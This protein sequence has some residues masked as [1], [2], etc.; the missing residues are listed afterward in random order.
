MSLKARTNSYG[1]FVFP[2]PFT[3]T[4]TVATSSG[5]NTSVANYVFE[6]HG[7]SRHGYSKNPKRTLHGVANFRPAADYT[8]GVFDCKTTDRFYKVTSPYGET[9]TLTEKVG[10]HLSWSWTRIGG[11]LSS[12]G[13]LAGVNWYNDTAWE[14]RAQSQIECL[15]R[16]GGQKAQVYVTLAE[17]IKSFNLLAST[18]GDL[19]AAARSLK[20]GNF[21]LAAK[22]LGLK[23][24]KGLSKRILEVN[25]GWAPLV[26][27]AIGAKEILDMYL[28][29]SP[30]VVSARRTIKTSQTLTNGGFLYRPDGAKN[31]FNN[32]K[33]RT[34]CGLTAVIDDKY[35]RIA[36]QAGAFNP[37]QLGWE[38]LPWSFIIDWVLPVGDF[39]EAMQAPVGLKF[40]TGYQSTVV[41]HEFECE[42]A[43]LP[44]GAIGQP[45]KYSGKGYVFQRSALNAWPRP[46][47]LYVK[48]PFKTRNAINALALIR[49]LI[50]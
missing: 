13:T 37:V 6:A 5:T 33:L 22:W 3:Q 36:N 48:S 39:I 7:C 9:T 2:E 10:G 46:L 31:W 27:E 25:Y 38:L 15:N 8:R 40:L 16:L 21:R 32:Q 30:L 47:P 20:H 41:E 43:P 49:Q 4:T 28:N 44:V 23:D 42:G 34:T 17:A 29:G 1:T 11:Q 14:A 45:G 24:T 50:R 19:A 26:Y 35:K 18:V 12:F